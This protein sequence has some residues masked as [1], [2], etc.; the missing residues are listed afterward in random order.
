LEGLATLGL[1]LLTAKVAEGVVKLAGMP[2]LLGPL[3]A[4]VLFGRILE[5]DELAPFA[6]LGGLLLVFFA[7]AEDVGK[8]ELNRRILKLSALAYIIPLLTALSLFPSFE[9]LKM[10]MVAALPGVGV[11]AKLIKERPYFEVTELLLALALAEGVGIVLYSWFEGGV[12]ELLVGA[13][14]ALASLKLGEL[15]LKILMKL[16]DY[17]HGPGVVAGTFLALL[18]LFMIIPESYGFSAV[19]MALAFGILMSEYLEERPWTMRRLKSLNDTLLEPLFFFSVGASARFFDPFAIVAA[20]VITA[21]KF[22]ALYLGTNDIKASLLGLAKG[23]ADS[24]LLLVS[25]LPPSLY[26]TAFFT[27]AL[28]ASI[29]SVV[30]RGGGDVLRLC[31]LPL[32]PARVEVHTP[33]EEVEKLLGPERPA[34]VVVRGERPIG[35][36][37]A[38]EVLAAKPG[39]SVDEVMNEG[40]P[41]FGCNTPLW[42]LLVLRTELGAP[43]VAV[44][45]GERFRGALLLPKLVKR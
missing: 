36:V 32:D 42:K 45:E 12:L 29:P 35:W 44:V 40:V 18:T 41:T 13:L 22:L 21:S 10:A 31:S 4:G 2:S 17:A 24:A 33:I 16:E 11:L 27:I 37:S 19:I 6:T 23:G 38:A 14:I 3:A 1:V 5:P 25:G 7:G 9:G 26:S 15:A 8:L 30:F 20:L 34:V 39:V 28:G 43:V